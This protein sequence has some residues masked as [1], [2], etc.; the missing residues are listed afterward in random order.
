MV[1]MEQKFLDPIGYQKVSFPS[2]IYPTSKKL[3]KKW[4]KKPQNH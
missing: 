1:A 4:P 3:D 2:L